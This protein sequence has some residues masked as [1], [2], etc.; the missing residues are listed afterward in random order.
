MI[1]FVM[2]FFLD[3]ISIGLHWML[4]NLGKM[5][6][7]HWA[8]FIAFI[9]AYKYFCVRGSSDATPSKGFIL[10]EKIEEL[11]RNHQLTDTNVSNGLLACLY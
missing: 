5:L 4:W 10:R 7:P 3:L 9:L 6:L 2:D 11:F 8:T 1:F